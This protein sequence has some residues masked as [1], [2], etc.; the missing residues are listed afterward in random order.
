MQRHPIRNPVVAF[1]YDFTVK[2]GRSYIELPSRMHDKGKPLVQSRPRR[3]TRRTS[4]ASIRTA[5]R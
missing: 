4:P 1:D 2:I 3:V 5:R